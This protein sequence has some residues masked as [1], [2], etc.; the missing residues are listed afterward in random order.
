MKTRVFILVSLCFF[1]LAVPVGAWAKPVFKIALL[2]DPGGETRYQR[3]TVEE[4]NALLKSRAAVEY[5]QAAVGPDRDARTDAVIAGI[6][7][8]DSVDCVIGI[9]IDPSEFLV[10][11]NRYDKPT[12]AATI[13][14]RRLQGLPMTPEGTSGIRNFNYI[15]S[16]FDIEKDL[17][18][19]KTLYDFK[20]LAVLLPAGHTVMFPTLFSYFGKAVETVSPASKLSIVD[21]DPENIGKSAAEIPPGADA[22]YLLPLYPEEREDRIE[23]LIRVVNRRGLPSFAMF[24][25]RHVRLG[26][27]A[28]IAPERNFNALTRRIAI[29]VLEILDGKDAG[30]L[31][32]MVSPYADNFVVNV[33]TFRKIDYFPGF[34]ATEEA[35][36]LNLDKLRQGPEIELKGIIL[37]ALK[38]NLDLRMAKADTES[39]AEAAGIARSALLPQVGLSSGIAHVDENR[40][41]IA[42]TIAART[43]WTVSGDVSQALFSDDLL[44]NHAIQNILLS[45]RGHQ[46]KT[47]LLDTVVTAAQAYIA[48]LSAKS[49]QAIRNNNLDVTRKNLDI[50]KNKAA[51]GSADASAVSRWESEKAGNLILLNDAHRDV[52]LARM[53]L[54]GVLDRPIDR[55]FTPVDIEPGTGIELMVADPEIYRLVGNFKQLARFSDFLVEEA[56]RNRPELRGVA[57]NIRSGER[58]LLNR[59]RARYLPDVFLTAGADKILAEYDAV[60]ETPSELDHPWSVAVAAS[61]PLYSGGARKKELALSRIRLRRT[62]LEEKNLR[63]RLHLNVRSSLET[64]AV[65]VR[66]IDLSENARLSAQKNFEVIQAGYSEGRKSVTDL[67]DAQNAM[68]AGELNAALARYQF[69]MDFLVLERSTGRF[70]FLDSPEQKRDFMNRLRHYMETTPAD[71]LTD[72]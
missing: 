5:L 24:G 8:D 42:G 57:E 69:V 29:N 27:M 70:H 6:M 18:T 17:R 7:A 31:P 30:A 21:I 66:R 43:T 10:R 26:A 53:A 64:A 1:L 44:A 34:K 20:H 15:L 72:P 48:L 23:A 11:L 56:D 59:K 65:S 32:V 45:A 46:E 52:Q 39:Q 68:V 63:N 51:V 33:E 60:R 38:R 58:R 40:V 3:R 9:G 37:E 47:V 55:E 71:D 50:A 62:R 25:E 2:S 41:E 49:N 14:D 36:L 61:W 16:P 22:V 19:F 28:A 35:R 12:I 13:L 4:I 54:N 67:V